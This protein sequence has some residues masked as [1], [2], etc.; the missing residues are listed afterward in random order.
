[1]GRLKCFK[2]LE[3]EAATGRQVVKRLKKIAADKAIYRQ[4]AECR[5]SKGQPAVMQAVS[6]GKVLPFWDTYPLAVC[7][8][9]VLPFQDTY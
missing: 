1:L 8:G 3:A 2:A 6:F 9:K 5:A 7:F 4:R